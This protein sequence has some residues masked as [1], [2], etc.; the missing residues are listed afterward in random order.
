[1]PASGHYAVAPDSFILTRGGIKK[2][3]ELNVGDSVLGIQAG[4]PRFEE[5][6]EISSQSGER[7]V[8]ILADRC[9]SLV[10]ARSSVF[11]LQGSTAASLI[12]R[13]DTLEMMNLSSGIMSDLETLPTRIIDTRYDI[14]L[15]PSLSYLL[16]TQLFAERFSDRVLVDETDPSVARE[17]ASEFNHTLGV[18]GIPHRI[19]LPRYGARIRIDSF[20]LAR[21]VAT[22]LGHAGNIPIEMR[23]SAPEVMRHFICGILDS[24][25]SESGHR[26]GEA[27]IRTAMK[28][29]EY[30]RFIF[31]VLRLYGAKSVSSRVHYP[32]DDLA[33]VDTYFQTVDLERLGLR[34]FRLHPKRDSD[35]DRQVLSYSKVVDV[36]MFRGS[37]TI[38]EVPRTGWTLES[39]LILVQ[40]VTT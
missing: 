12:A 33:Y 10:S 23:V 34:F 17:L 35:G 24:S 7:W 26:Q 19:F 8:R 25:I 16:G 27:R 4:K 39:D 40:R 36:N 6:T 13:E 21:L 31:Q 11:T 20:R 38:L 22:F 28:D 37:N 14:S 18:C 3:R 15:S 2:A 30:R 1:M 5:L 32:Q 9:E 29:S